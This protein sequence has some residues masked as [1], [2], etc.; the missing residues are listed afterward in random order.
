MG[1][2]ANTRT[3]IGFVVV[4]RDDAMIA[5]IYIYFEISYERGQCNMSPLSVEDVILSIMP[6]IIHFY[7]VYMAEK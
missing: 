4:L 5:S 7:I 6:L 2:V 1:G 3:S